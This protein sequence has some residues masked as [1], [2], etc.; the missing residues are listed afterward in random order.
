MNVLGVGSE[1]RQ[2][3]EFK[4]ARL[5]FEGVGASGFQVTRVRIVC[6][7]AR[8]SWVLGNRLPCFSLITGF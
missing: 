1:F 8:P 6:S 5:R 3:L 4:V 2:S 7:A